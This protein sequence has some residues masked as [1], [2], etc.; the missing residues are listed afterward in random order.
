M[1]HFTVLKASADMKRYYA[2]DYYLE[3][4]ETRAFFGGALADRLGLGAFDRAHFHALCDGLH[5]LTGA[6][7]TPGRKG[8]ARAGWD[9]TIDGP[10]DLGVLLGLG[11]DDRIVPQVIERAGRDLM[12]LIERDAFTRVRVGGADRDRPTGAIVYSG[13]VH[14]TARPVGTKVDVQPHIHFLVANA[15][16]D[17]VEGRYKALQLQPFVGNGARE[18][19]PFYTA[20]LNNQMARYLHELGYRTEPDRKNQSF[21]VVGVP[22]S[23][24]KEFSQRT[25]KIEAVAATLERQKRAFVGDPTATLDPAKK[26]EL[27]AR[28]RE[29]KRPGQTWASLLDHWAGRVS[30]AERRAVMETVIRSR[31]APHAL[32]PDRARDAVSYALAHLTERETVVTERR[33]ITEALKHGL[34]S[35]TVRTLTAELNRRPDVI[36][37]TVG[38]TPLVTTTAAL[39]TERTITA[40]AVKDRGRNRSLAAPGPVSQPSADSVPLTVSQHAAVRH[41]LTSRDRLIVVQGRAGTGKTTLTRTAVA[42]IERAGLPVQ[43]LAPSVAAPRGVLRQDGFQ[44]ANTLT[45]FLQDEV[46]QARVRGGVVWLDEAGLASAADFAALCQAA[47]SLGARVVVSGDARQHNSVAAGDVFALLDRVGLPVAEVTEVRRQ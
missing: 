30:A 13:I 28:T 17:A 24:R 1:V 31:R 14:L 10:K 38:G 9:V 5:P 34:G 47:D 21:R 32:G 44:N 8:N 7:L 23:V 26:G 11:L 46:M 2:P 18:A 42:A 41:V 33:I 40:F 39:A 45:A 35:V 29:P 12:Q 19:R 6:K 27:G 37:R 36:R 15:T 20:F 16:W 3:R 22:E 43:M 25:H 4:A